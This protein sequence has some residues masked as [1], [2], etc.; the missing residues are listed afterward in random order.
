MLHDDR[1]MGDAPRH[2]HFVI[3][4]FYLLPDA[5]L[6]FMARV[7][8]FERIEAGANSDDQI[9]EIF[10]FHIARARTHIDAIAGMVPYP[11]RRNIA[12]S[13]VKRLDT[14]ASPGARVFYRL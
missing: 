7:C 8:H 3:R 11:I 14:A 13:M 9:G 1:G 5:P 4:K 2:Q 12:Q 10:E 6:M